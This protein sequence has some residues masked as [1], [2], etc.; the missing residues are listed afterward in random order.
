MPTLSVRHSDERAAQFVVPPA[1]STID[2]HSHTIHSD[3]L[4]TPSTLVDAAASAGVRLLSVTDHDTLAGVRALTAPGAPPLP[5]GLELV[6]GV[7]INAVSRPGEPL[8]GEIHV[9]GLGVDPADEAF[10]AALAGQ[11]TERLR[12]FLG[13]VERLREIGMPIDEDVATLDLTDD[14]ALGRP[15]LARI[16]VAR[17]H[18]ETVDDAFV[19]LLGGGGPAYVPRAGLGPLEAI[20]AI[21]GAGGLPVLA[22]YGEAPDRPGVIGE[23]M[24]AGLGG[25]EAYHRSFDPPTAD[26][27]AAFA[28]ARGLVVT[29]GTDYHGDVSTYAESHAGLRVPPEVAPA[30]REALRGVSVSRLPAR[31]P[32]PPRG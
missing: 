30:L 24:E 29:G 13:I 5:P 6:P 1:P 8:R 16:L 31:A 32:S 22:H 3:G 25:L 17:G 19:R 27:L 28:A 7:E 11:R 14:H 9:L 15:T 12:R 10:E 23:L 18:A 20:R 4:L 21:R 26:A 2:L